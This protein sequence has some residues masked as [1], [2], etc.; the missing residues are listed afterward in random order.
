MNSSDMRCAVAGS[1]CRLT[2][3]TEPKAATGSDSRALT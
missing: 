3:T 2:A 1:I